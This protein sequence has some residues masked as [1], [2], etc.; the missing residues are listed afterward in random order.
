MCRTAATTIDSRCS[1]SRLNPRT[2]P[3][4]SKRSLSMPPSASGPTTSR[5]PIH[6]AIDAREPQ[7]RPNPHRG[8]SRML[9]GVDPVQPSVRAQSNSFGTAAILSQIA[10][11]RRIRSATGPR[12]SVPALFHAVNLA[13]RE[14]R[15]IRGRAELIAGRRAIELGPSRTCRSAYLQPAQ[16]AVGPGCR[17]KRQQKLVSKVWYVSL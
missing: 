12:T 3:P 7:T 1:T 15:L 6:Q 17:Q 16:A 8:F 5:R 13:Q 2:R 9:R 10:S 14:A 11:T 4:Y